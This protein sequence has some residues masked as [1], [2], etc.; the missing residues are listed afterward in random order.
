MPGTLRSSVYLP[1]PVVFSAASTMAVG[2]PIIEN[3]AFIVRQYEAFS[4]CLDRRTY[5]GVHLVVAGA[6]AQIAA[7][8]TAHFCFR[9]IWVLRQ[10]RLDGHDEPRRAV[11][12][13]C[14]APV[15]ISFLNRCQASVLSHT[16]DGRDLLCLT[17]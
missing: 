10:E 4:L 7:Q 13:L 5:R 16:F 8:S 9:R 17:T 12:A 3:S 1:A 15:P 2:L 14:T 6:T 11:A